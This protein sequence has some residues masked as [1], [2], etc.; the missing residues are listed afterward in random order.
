M[1]NWEL[2]HLGLAKHVA[3]WS[4]DPNK[5]CGAVIADHNNMIVS[6]GYN[7]FAKGV[8]DD[9]RAYQDK[10]LKLQKIIHAEVN[11]ILYA[12]RALEGH[13]IYTYPFPPCARCATVII[14]SGI[15]RVVFPY[16]EDELVISSWKD[17]LDIALDMFQDAGI[18]TNFIDGE[19]S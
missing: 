9:P 11:A 1:A 8:K 7:G 2:R 4:K 19:L 13:T 14:Q 18:I 16:N 6:L 5:K 17:S 3:E 15:S 10:D 12:R